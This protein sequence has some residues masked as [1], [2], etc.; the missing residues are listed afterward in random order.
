MMLVAKRTDIQKRRE[1]KG[2]SRKKLSQQAGLPDN[3][4]CRIE[5]GE[6]KYTHPLR[7]AAISQALGC[8]VEDIFYVDKQEQSA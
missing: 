6:N 7:A 5:R 8:K 3:A 1:A 4:V 2:L